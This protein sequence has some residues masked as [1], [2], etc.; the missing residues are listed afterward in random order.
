M[1]ECKNIAVFGYAEKDN[2][3]I[4]VQQN[5]GEGNWHLPGGTVDHDEDIYSAVKRE[6]LE[7]TGLDYIEPQLRAIIYSRTNFAVVFLF[8]GKIGSGEMLME[9]TREI[10]NRGWFSI[11]K[12]PEPMSRY[13]MHR[14]NV[15]K[16]MNDGNVHFYEFD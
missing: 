6:F 4:L 12:L 5:Y 11:D 15:V 3:L 1:S 14:M 16:E 7:E 10:K 9:Q 2:K 13:A 8:E